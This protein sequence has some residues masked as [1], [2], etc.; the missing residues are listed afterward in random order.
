MKAVATLGSGSAIVRITN[1]VV[2]GNRTGIA[3]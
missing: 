2:T 1:Y 3:L